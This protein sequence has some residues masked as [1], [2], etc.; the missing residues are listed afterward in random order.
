MA[1][2]FQA[3]EAAL[4]QPQYLQVSPENANQE[5]ITLAT[6]PGHEAI[7]VVDENGQIQQVQ[8]QR[9]RQLEVG[10]QVVLGQLQ[11]QLV[12]AGI[13]QNQLDGNQIILAQTNSESREELLEETQRIIQQIQ[14][15]LEPT[16]G[17]GEEGGQQ[18]KV[19]YHILHDDDNQQIVEI[20]YHP[21]GE[22]EEQ[23]QDGV[24]TVIDEGQTNIQ[25]IENQGGDEVSD[26]DNASQIEIQPVEL[27]HG[28]LHQ[29]GESNDIADI[30]QDNHQVQVIEQN[31]PEGNADQTEHQTVQVEEL[32]ATQ[33]AHYVEYQEVDA[34]DAHATIT[35]HTPV[36]TTE[37]PSAAHSEKDLVVEQA[38]YE[39]DAQHQVKGEQSPVSSMVENTEENPASNPQQTE[40]TEADQ[41]N[42]EPMQEGS[43]AEEETVLTFEML[44]RQQQAASVDYVSHPDFNCQEYYNWL[45]SFTELCKLVPVPLSVELFQKIS[46]VHKT[47]SDVLATPR[48]ILTNRDNFRTLMNISKELNGIINEHLAFVLQQLD[49]DIDM[50]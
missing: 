23:V 26:V 29:L 24:L 32:Q 48:G 15:Q 10:G 16:E 6:E 41:T 14:S 30:T 5:V 35:N 2:Q 4:N 40:N 28:A 21:V 11:Q 49:T 13:N 1:E 38:N 9:V 12:Q 50:E 36:V 22:G 3:E 47:L 25:D 27:A 31:S 19:A 20:Q 43:G 42:E 37:Q 46:Q 45:S 18:V 39:I 8:V 17:T 7:Q 34:N 33:Q 44:E